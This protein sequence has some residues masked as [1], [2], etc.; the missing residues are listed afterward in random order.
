[1]TDRPTGTFL[2]RD[3]LAELTGWRVRKKQIEWLQERN[4]PHVVNGLGW[5]VVRRAVMEGKMGGTTAK[6]AWNMD[7]ANVA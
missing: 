4:W 3:E 1:M 5:P 2:T 7:D 6:P